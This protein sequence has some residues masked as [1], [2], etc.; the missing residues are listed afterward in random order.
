MKK[1]IILP[2]VVLLLSGCGFPKRE[3]MTNEEIIAE[4]KKC[5]EAGLGASM[6]SQGYSDATAL[7]QCDIKK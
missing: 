5:E 4:V 6:Y 2:I 3:P 1:F 7:V